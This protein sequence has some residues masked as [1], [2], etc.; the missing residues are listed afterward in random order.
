MGWGG[1]SKGKW[2]KEIKFETEIKKVSNKKR[3]K[4]KRRRGGGGDEGEEAE[5]TYHKRTQEE[6]QF[7]EAEDEKK[8]RGTELVLPNHEYPSL[9]GGQKSCQLTHEPEANKMDF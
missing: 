1:G 9:W 4:K 3:F 7:I 2:Q 5:T 8:T 6:T